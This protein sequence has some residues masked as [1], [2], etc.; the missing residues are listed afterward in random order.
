MSPV[1]PRARRSAVLDKRVELYASE[2]II[3]EITLRKDTSQL[4]SR[5]T[6]T[7]ALCVCVCVY[8]P[9]IQ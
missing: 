5:H 6:D 3:R 7:R 8:A 4:K 1:Q 2:H 9:S